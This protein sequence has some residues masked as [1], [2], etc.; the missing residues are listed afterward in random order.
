MLW[1]IGLGI[2]G[3]N[4]IS[5]ETQKIISHADFVYMELFTS[6]ISKA[7]PAKFKKLTNG[8]FKIAK[9]W[10]VEDG[11]EILKNAKKNKVVLYRQKQLAPAYFHFNLS[12]VK[13]KFPRASRKDFICDEE[14]LERYTEEHIKELHTF[15][16]H[17][18]CDA[19]CR[20]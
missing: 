20:S 1:F 6:P 14:H 18:L 8:E 15:G 16:I 3:P 7:D 12:C 19:D 9:R 11:T 10:M 5:V 17:T 4:S 2:T 13:N